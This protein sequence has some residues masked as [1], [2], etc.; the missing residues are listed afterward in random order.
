MN[1][2]IIFITLFFIIFSCTEGKKI[3]KKKKVTKNEA[4]EKDKIPKNTG[5]KVKERYKVTINIFDNIKEAVKNTEKYI[6]D[7]YSGEEK[8]LSTKKVK[9]IKSTFYK[10][11]TAKENAL[12]LQYNRFFIK[13]AFLPENETLKIAKQFVEHI[14]KNMVNVKIPPVESKQSVKDLLPEQKELNDFQIVEGKKFYNKKN[15]YDLV[16]GN[17]ATY[18]SYGFTEGA[19]LVLKNKS[20]SQY[21]IEIYD[22]ENPLNAFGIFSRERSKDGKETDFGYGGTIDKFSSVFWMDKFY[23]KVIEVMNGKSE[24]KDKKKLSKLISEKIKTEKDANPLSNII[25]IFPK[26][27][28]IQRSGLYSTSVEGY[29]YLNKGLTFSYE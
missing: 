28:I 15:L 23:I 6:S 3:D 26:E 10:G 24:S 16:D 11:D 14:K 2:I 20:G 1:K 17:D 7:Q 27:K 13:I 9:D 12:V 8:K 19:T 4:V 25:S 22:M 5:S 29:E 21:R 18:Q